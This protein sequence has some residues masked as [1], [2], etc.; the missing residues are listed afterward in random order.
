MIFILKPED[1]AIPSSYRPISFLDTMGKLFEKILVSSILRVVNEH[2]LL[3]DEQFVLRPRRNTLQ[4]ARLVERITWDFG[5]KRLNGA[6]FL[7]VAKA[8][9][10][11][12][13]D[14]LH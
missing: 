1:P 9:D 10:T 11:D 2:G 4:L 13:I 5:E 3:R 6:I 14:D 12:W 7:D 8:F